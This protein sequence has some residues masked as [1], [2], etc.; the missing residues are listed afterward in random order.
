MPR[1]DIEGTMVLINGIMN[2]IVLVDNG[3]WDVQ[4]LVD[5]RLRIQEVPRV[6]QPV[7]TERAKIWQFPNGTPDLGDVAACRRG[8]FRQA[9]PEPDAARDDGNLPR[10]NEQP[11]QLG[12][13][14]KGTELRR[15][16]EVSV[17]IA[18]GLVFHRGVDHVHIQRKSLSQVRVTATAQRV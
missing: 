9:D 12:L 11:S 14:V 1:D 5:M 7:A 2:A 17:G 18:V 3:E 13:D 6:R 15:K 10:L 8:A 4:V 16:Q